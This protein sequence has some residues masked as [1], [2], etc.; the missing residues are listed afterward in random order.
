M[1]HRQLAAEVTNHNAWVPHPSGFE[2]CA[3]GI[4]H[5]LGGCDE[6]GYHGTLR[7]FGVSDGI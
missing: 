7:Y 6:L 3:G 5:R 4:K 1:P 2:G